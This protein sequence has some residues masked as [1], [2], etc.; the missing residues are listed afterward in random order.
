MTLRWYLLGIAGAAVG[1]AVWA[2]G[3]LRVAV[4]VAA[5][6]VA[7]AGLL[8][9]DAWAEL[10][11]PL[12][13]ARSPPPPSPRD[14]LRRTFRTG[15]MGRE[16]LVEFLDRL[17]REGPNPSL[18][19]RRSEEVRELLRLSPRE[20]RGYLAQRLDDLEARS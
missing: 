9:V 16:E 1:V 17:E 15:R 11:G 10:G 3:N 18:P 5:I 12:L 2:G 13:E 14:D 8:F 19:R 7:A 4:P 6:A 20:F